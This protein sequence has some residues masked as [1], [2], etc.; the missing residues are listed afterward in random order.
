MGWLELIFD[1]ITTTLD[2]IIQAA[3]NARVRNCTVPKEK[4]KADVS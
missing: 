3:P 4:I 2:E 1:E